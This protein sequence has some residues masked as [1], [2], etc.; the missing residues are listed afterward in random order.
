VLTGKI[1]CDER[2]PGIELVQFQGPPGYEDEMLSVENGLSNGLR[3]QI[4]NEDLDGWAAFH[5][6]D[7]QTARLIAARLVEWSSR[8]ADPPRIAPV[9]Q[10]RP[11]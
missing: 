5:I 1:I 10:R 8:I 3:L 4:L 6:H 7:P 2:R 11:G 9:E